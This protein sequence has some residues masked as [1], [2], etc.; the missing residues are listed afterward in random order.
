MRGF[1]F[2]IVN[3]DLSKAPAQLLDLMRLMEQGQ[4]RVAERVDRLLAEL[5][6]FHEAD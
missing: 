2:V 1:D 6:A 3:D 4:L 5:E